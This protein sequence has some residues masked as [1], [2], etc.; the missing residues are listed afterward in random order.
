L[1]TSAEPSK[2]DDQGSKMQLDMIA[3][4]DQVGGQVRPKEFKVQIVEYLA[5]D[6]ALLY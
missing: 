1:A 3:A 5:L 6:K 2:P 4:R